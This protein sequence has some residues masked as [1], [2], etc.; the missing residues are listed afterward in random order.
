GDYWLITPA[1]MARITV[2]DAPFLAVELTVT[3]GGAAQILSLRTNVDAVVTVDDTHPIRI[4]TDPDTGMPKPYVVLG[5]GVEAKI[6]RAVY[7]ELVALATEKTP[8][9]FGVWSSGA[10]FPLSQPGETA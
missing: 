4:R 10:F 3:G 9:T 5:G 7:Y 2:E 6:A 8:G 1:E